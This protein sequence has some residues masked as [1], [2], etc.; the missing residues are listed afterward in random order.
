MTQASGQQPTAQGSLE[1]TPLVHLLV[2]MADRRVSGS[3]VLADPTEPAGQEHGV[4]FVDGTASKFRT[5]KPVAHLGRVL[6][7]LGYVTEQALNDSL[8]A[9]AGRGELHGEY[10]CRTGA[11]ERTKLMTGLREQ[12]QR[13]MAFLLGLPNTTHYAF[14]QDLNL[15]ENWG[16]PELTPLEPLATIWTAVSARGYEPVVDAMLGRLGSTTLKLHEK[17]EVTRFGFSPQELGVIDLIRA[18]PCTLAAIVE[19]GILPKRRIELIVY[20]LF[21]TRHLDHRADAAPPIGLSLLSETGRFRATSSTTGN[22]PLARVKLATRSADPPSEVRP[23]QERISTAPSSSPRAMP[24]P[25][26]SADGDRISSLPPSAAM[27]TPEL[28]ARRQAVLTRAEGIDR[29]NYFSMLGVT[30]DAPEAEIQA[31]YYALAK[32]WHPDRLPAELARVR[33]LASK[34]FARMS[35]A[36]DTLSDPNK[37]KR[38]VDVM[39]GGGGTPEEADKIQQILDAA[40]DFQRGEILWKKND[41]GAEQYILRAY[42]ADPEQAD[43]VA[44]YATLQLSKRPPDAAVDDLIRLCDEAIDT[45][46]RCERAYFCRGMLRKR[47]GKMDAAMSDFRAA[48]EIN[49]KNLDAAREVRLY[50]M[51]RARQSPE[52]QSNPGVRR[53]NPPP[54]NKSMVSGRSSMPPRKT[55]SSPTKKEGGVLSG[56]GKLFKR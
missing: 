22:V 36:F 21:V 19:T 40:S 35:E 2:Y 3:L 39:R 47:I 20:T 6:Y 32:T 50:E 5:G 17:S 1:K 30:K 16:G 23:G 34:V 42:Q 25:P 54:G 8:A 41:P 14:Y 27:L 55:P 29:E 46:E 28:A 24:A 43:Y 9:I 7:E 49:P 45:H 10:L 4:Y 51:R 13:K 11:I 18:R 48:Y 56:I 52:R 37:R 31:A 38:Y 12:S 15:L 26:A 33:E 44:L 53:S